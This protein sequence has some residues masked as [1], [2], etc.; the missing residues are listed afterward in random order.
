MRVPT[1]FML[2]AVFILTAGC[3]AQAQTV[4]PVDQA[5]ILAGSRFD[6]KVELPERVAQS[7]IRITVNGADY[8]AAFGKPVTYIEKEDGKEQSAL[9]A[10][11]YRT[12][13]ARH[14]RH[15]SVGRNR[16]RDLSWNVYDTSARKAKNVIL[17]IGDGMSPAHRVAARLLSK[18]ISEGTFARQ[19]RDRR[20]A[21]NGFGRDRRHRFDHH[22]FR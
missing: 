14:L 1:R 9:Y 8:T 11:R 3:V 10:A 15:Q 18:G 16:S 22:G 13:Q 4:Y 21:A 2:S 17:F 7:D 19:T 12:D 6:F 5:Q 20:H